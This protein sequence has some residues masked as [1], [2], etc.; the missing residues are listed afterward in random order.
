MLEEV[1]ILF[2]ISHGLAAR[3]AFHTELV[4]SIAQHGLRLGFVTASAGEPEAH[5]I[6]QRLNLRLF[7]PPPISARLGGQYN[8]LRRYIFEDVRKNPAL[9]E[10]HLRAVDREDSRLIE[11]VQAR[12]YMLSNRISTRFP[13][14]RGALR[15][16]ERRLLRNKGVA[17]LLADLKP[18]LLVS[19]YP[20]SVLEATFLL[21]AQR[22]GITTVGQLL[23][24]DNITCKGRFSVVPDYFITWGPI[25]S[26]ELEEY[27][28][29]PPERI[30]Q[31]GVPHF[32][33][34]V[35][36]P[37]PAGVEAEVTALGLDPQRPYM[38]FGM[39]APYFAPR[40]IDIVEW[41]ARQV[42]EN[43]FGDQMQLVVRPHPQNVQ[44]SMAD[45]SW[46]PRLDRIAGPRVAV[47]Y[48]S[49]ENSRLE[50]NL[51][52]SDLAH[53]VN[54]ISGCSLLLNS[55]STL[56]IDA[57]IHDKPV[58]VTSF[59]AEA[60]LAWFKSARRALDFYHYAKLV[61]TGGV[62]VV[63]SFDQLDSAITRYLADPSADAAGRARAREQE[64]GYTDGR[65]AARV[66]DALATLHKHGSFEPA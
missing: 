63:R 19:S 31:T 59:D 27:Y 13:P 3:M 43:R 53:L 9:W 30:R 14:M 7:S 62:R 35:N 32:D 17:Q 40:E 60:D 2:V 56:S 65:S 48:P 37:D 41:L 47:D 16:I 20:V 33:A 18:K 51:K 29:V 44:G 22:A 39:S 34:H 49:L 26:A 12:C 25:M 54:L 11:R 64:V 21:E 5:D 52:E 46:L 38:L 15:M 55:G 10:K 36:M 61:A 4:P 57:L 6:A 50:W 8:K 42:N 28:Q 45:Q 58:I 1:D 66:A 24:W 23:S